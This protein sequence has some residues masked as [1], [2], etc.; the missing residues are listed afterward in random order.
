MPCLLRGGGGS[1]VSLLTPTSWSAPSPLGGPAVLWVIHGIVAEFPMLC[2][3]SSAHLGW[4]EGGG[5]L[6]PACT[7]PSCWGGSGSLQAPHPLEHHGVAH[8]PGGGWNPMLWGRAAMGLRLVISAPTWSCHELWGRLG[9]TGAPR[10]L[11]EPTAVCCLLWRSVL[12][13]EVPAGRRLA[14]TSRK[15]CEGELGS[16]RPSA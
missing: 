4:G 2:C 12:T 6:L 1:V 8:H 7:S 5:S 13:G 14:P 11:P 10:E 3:G 15:G 16:C 9:S